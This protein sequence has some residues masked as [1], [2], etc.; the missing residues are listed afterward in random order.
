[1]TV[2]R[3]PEFREWLD[4]Q[5]DPEWGL[6]P[7]THVC[8]ALVGQD[9][10]RE[11]RIEPSDC[12]VFQRALAYFFYGR[13][14][15][16]TR[17]D[18]PIKNLAACPMCFI[19]DP[20]MLDR[21]QEI[22][23]FDTGAFNARLYS[24]VMMEEMKI[25]DFSLER[26][27]RRPNKLIRAVY[28][29]REAYFE[30]GKLKGAELEATIPAAE[31]LT[32]SYIDLLRSTGRNE[33]DDRVG[34]IEVVF[35]DPVPLKGNLIAIATPDLLWNDKDQVN[36]LASLAEAGVDILPFRYAHRREPEHHHAMIEV[37]VRNYFQARGDL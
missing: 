15:Y 20:R 8:K 22:H 2:G 12:D 26:E 5:T 32:R 3:R 23:P 6:M 14:A 16:R 35:G 10:A 7:L 21:A 25:A 36:W 34:S 19:F 18:G 31:F 13:P 30:G 4:R 24:H 33:P 28:G 11:G 9:I 17:G 27:S 1:M 29:T 37:E